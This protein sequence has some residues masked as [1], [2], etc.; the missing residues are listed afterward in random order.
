MNVPQDR[1]YD[2]LHILTMC[3]IFLVDI[4]L[5][6][7]DDAPASI[8]SGLKQVFWQVLVV[9]DSTSRFFLGFLQSKKSDLAYYR[10][11]ARPLSRDAPPFTI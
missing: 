6:K 3:S 1:S 4:I 2:P 7:R 8:F 10:L 5:G 11:E 9:F